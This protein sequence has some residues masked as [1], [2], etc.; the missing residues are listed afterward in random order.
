MNND[1]VTKTLAVQPKTKAPVGPNT[2]HL[3]VTMS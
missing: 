1:C 2:N 3:Q